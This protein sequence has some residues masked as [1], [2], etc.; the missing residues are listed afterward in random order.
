MVIEIGTKD[1]VVSLKDGKLKIFDSENGKLS[2]SFPSL[3]SNEKVKTTL[4][5]N[6]IISPE[7]TVNPSEKWI[8]VVN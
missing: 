5:T 6:N 8:T 7:L 3:L 2:F 4:L 1:Y